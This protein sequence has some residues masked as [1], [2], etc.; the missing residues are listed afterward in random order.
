L[1]ALLALF[2]GHHYFGE[3]LVVRGGGCGRRGR[4]HVGEARKSADGARK[5]QKAFIH[6]SPPGPTLAPN[7]MVS[8]LVAFDR[9]D[10]TPRGS[11]NRHSH[12]L[13]MGNC[14]MF[15]GASTGCFVHAT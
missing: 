3:A 7:I 14:V 1:K 13:T 6:L 12:R 5:Q 15:P 8:F 4:G 9:R 10:F 11:Q 2:S